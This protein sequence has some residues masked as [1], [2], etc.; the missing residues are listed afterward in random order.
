M[1]IQWKQKIRAEEFARLS[2]GEFRPGKDKKLLLTGFC[3]DSREAD[4]ETVFVA[5]RGEKNDGHDYIPDALKCGCRCILCERSSEKIEYAGAGAVVVKDTEIALAV[6]ANSWN[7][8]RS[9]KRVAVT[10]SVGKT[11]TKDLIASVLGVGYE[12]FKTAGN[13]NSVIGMPMEMTAIPK[14]TEW[15]VL[16][17]GMS[18]FGEIERL[19]ITAE[20]DVAVITNIGTSHLEMMESR[21]NIARAKLEVLCGLRDGGLLILNGDEPL[22]AKV[23]GT[24]YTTQY[25]SLKRPKADFYADHIR[26]EPGR[27]VFDATV[28]GKRMLNLSISVMGKHNVY[29]ALYAIAVG[30]RAG[31]DEEQIRRGLGNFRPE[32]MRQQIIEMGGITVIEDCY[33]AAPESVRAGIDVLAEYCE[34]TG[35]RSIAVL[36]DM[37]ELGTQSP[38][39][40]CSVGSYVA[41]KKLK[42]LV[43]MGEG[44][45]LIALGAEKSGM[46]GR[47]IQRFRDYHDRQKIGEA[48]ETLLRP[49]DAVLIKASRA[50]G[51]EKIVEYL[52]TVFA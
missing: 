7:R 32:G 40:H 43:T 3:T 29:D 50:V 35:K 38:E 18:G 52:K 22:L 8:D 49:G 12:T 25:V 10:G 15:A 34:E 13:H 36:G 6:L 45:E 20:P 47:N 48:L 21:E 51:A 28:M 26:V 9:F 31:L 46:P 5:L 14:N 33:N 24:G 37:K 44:G 17:M 16:E 11:T 42:K 19:S 41:A 27:T 1:K 4:E 23:G 2:G 30:V 39:L